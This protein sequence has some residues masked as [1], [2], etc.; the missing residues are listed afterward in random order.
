VRFSISWKAYCFADEAERR[1]WRE[2]RDDLALDAILDRLV[3]DLRERGRIDGERPEPTALALLLIDEYVRF[4]AADAGRGARVGMTRLTI[5][6]VCLALA[7]VGAAPA[8]RRPSS[9]TRSRSRTCGPDQQRPQQQTAGKN[10]CSRS[11]NHRRRRIPNAAV[12]PVAAS[13]GERAAA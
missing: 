6:G 4:P 1:A 5:A 11:S 13:A 7:V 2:H 9:S 3:D 12:A 10:R 8:R